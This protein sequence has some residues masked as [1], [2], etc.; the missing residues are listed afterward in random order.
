VG[1]TV[2]KTKIVK[3]KP[4]LTITAP[5]VVSQG[6]KVTVAGKVF[7]G[8]NAA[9]PAGVVVTL[10]RRIGPSG[11]ATVKSTKIASD[12]SYA[13]VMRQR[14]GSAYRVRFPGDTTIEPGVS[15]ITRVRLNAPTVAQRAVHRAVLAKAIADARVSKTLEKDSRFRKV[16]L[17][18]LY[19]TAPPSAVKVEGN[20]A[21]L[22]TATQWP[23]HKSARAYIALIRK[24]NGRWL[25]VHSHR[26]DPKCAAVDGQGWPSTLVKSC[27]TK[28]KSLRSPA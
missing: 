7:V 27:V 10:Q 20:Y 3:V 6:K 28:Q 11:W 18:S 16:D 4:T 15:P 12:G 24:V 17:T 5:K 19:L 14:A 8:K 25:M 26:G 23:G 1:K 9:V 13:F 2:T 22:E 21:K